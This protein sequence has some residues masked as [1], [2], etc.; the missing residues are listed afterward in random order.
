MVYHRIRTQLNWAD[1][2]A[3]YQMYLT[4]KFSSEDSYVMQL[5]SFIIFCQSHNLD[6]D[7]IVK[8]INEH[9]CGQN[10]F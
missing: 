9:K 4:C 2:Q 8:F 5:V 6:E 7:K 1:V 10:L 3:I